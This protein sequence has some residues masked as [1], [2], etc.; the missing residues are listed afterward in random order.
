MYMHVFF[1]NF[2]SL[3]VVGL[4]YTNENLHIQTSYDE[5]KGALLPVTINN[6]NIAENFFKGLVDV[7]EILCKNLRNLYTFVHIFTQ[8]C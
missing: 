1:C 6:V 3:S 8:K 5:D 4:F 7:T 2:F